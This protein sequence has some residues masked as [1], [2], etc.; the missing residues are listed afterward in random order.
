MRFQ[1]HAASCGPASLRTA[2]MARGVTRSEDELAKL[3][4]CTTNGTTAKGMMK[5][6]LLVAKEHPVLLPGV[7]SES[8]EEIALMWLAQAHRA[9]YAAIL[10]VDNDE[11]WVVSFGML[12][13]SVFHIADSADEEMVLHYTRP[14]LAARW[15]GLGK[16]PFYGIVV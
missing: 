2:L 5:A 3:S 4:G 15:R 12:G 1:S 8:R 10:C 7:L 13:E 16:K 6:L 14:Q 11:H 9:G